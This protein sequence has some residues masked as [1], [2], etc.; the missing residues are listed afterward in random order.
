MDVMFILLLIVN[1]INTINLGYLDFSCAVLLLLV[2][3]VFKGIYPSNKWSKIVHN[4][5][6]FA[7]QHL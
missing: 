7:F 1:L 5:S 6:L 4:I 2:N 3:Y